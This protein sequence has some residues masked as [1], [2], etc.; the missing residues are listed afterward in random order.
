MTSLPPRR[1]GIDAFAALA[2]FGESLPATLRLRLFEKIESGPILREVAAN[3]GSFEP[4]IS[5]LEQHLVPAAIELGEAQRSLYGLLLAVNL[6]EMASALHQRPLLAA[7]ARGGQLSLALGLAKSLPTA[8][9]QIRARAW[10][11]SS[12]PRAHPRWDVLKAELAESVRP[13][14]ESAPEADA[15]EAARRAETYA[16]LARELPAEFQGSLPNWLA[17]LAPWPAQAPN[18]TPTTG[19]VR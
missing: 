3:R 14:Q 18:A 12:L 7:L 5:A 10:I 2:K 13:W 1:P 16:A 15:A 8:S 19:T 9:E 4:L 11:L 6:R 17:R